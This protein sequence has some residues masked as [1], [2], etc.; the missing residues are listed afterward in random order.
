MAARTGP[1]LLFT[2]VCQHNDNDRK[3]SRPLMRTGPTICKKMWKR[4][5]YMYRPRMHLSAPQVAACTCNHSV[6]KTTARGMV[7]HS[8]QRPAGQDYTAP[9]AGLKRKAP[10]AKG[11][12]VASA[13]PGRLQAQG[14]GKAPQAGKAKPAR[15]GGVAAGVK[16]GAAVE[17]GKYK[18]KAKGKAK[19]KSDIDDIFAGVKRLK[20]EKAEEEAERWVARVCGRG[21][22]GGPTRTGT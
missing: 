14:K 18:G 15:Q 21:F 11:K 9:T 5:V 22:G 6:T 2:C 8:D 1:V 4:G 7:P 10:T 17:G 12:G 19:G 13:D 3:K 16:G 20:A